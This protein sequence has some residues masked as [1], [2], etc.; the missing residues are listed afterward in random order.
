METGLA[1]WQAGETLVKLTDIKP[2]LA[3]WDAKTHP[4]QIR[5]QAYLD[6]VQQRI[7]EVAHDRLFLHLEVDVEQQ[8]RLEKHHDLENYLTPLVARLGWSK[9]VLATATKFVGGGSTLTVGKAV[10]G[11]RPTF[12]SL[13]F[14]CTCS[15]DDVK[16]EV[17]QRLLGQPP[18][19]SGPVEVWHSWRCPP[20][21]NWVSLWKPTGDGMGPVL[22]EPYPDRPY[23]PNDDRI[24][25][26]AMHL[27]VDP[28]LPRAARTVGV[29]WRPF[30]LPQSAP[31]QPGRLID[32]I[33]QAARKAGADRQPVRLSELFRSFREQFPDLQLG[34][35][36]DSYSATQNFYTINMKSRWNRQIPE[37]NQPWVRE[38]LFKWV[39][40]GHYMLLTPAEIGAFQRAWASGNPLVR[41]D[42][43]ELEDLKEQRPYA[44]PTRD[45]ERSKRRKNPHSQ[46][47]Q[48]DV[49]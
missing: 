9:F 1:F 24:V 33:V 44:D 5:L 35:S 26:I 19:P 21:Q 30:Q 49:S 16:K 6:D 31:R 10:A 32:Y 18:L 41:A 2:L 38:P 23:Y 46:G 25:S 39:S 42:E 47:H 40:R 14:E 17:R 43:F 37:E 29:Y 15:S 4:S 3:S 7:G 12:S 27:T 45:P 13:E 11:L 22:G 28:A 36:E 34:S 48:S 20:Q 8:Q